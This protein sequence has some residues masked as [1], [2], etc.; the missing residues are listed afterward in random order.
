MAP[1]E[2]AYSLMQSGR[3]DPE[4]VPPAG[5]N[6]RRHFMSRRFDRLEGGEK[7]HMQSLCALRIS[8]STGGATR[9]SKRC[10]NP[11][12]NCPWKR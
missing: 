11:Q 12:L 1:I 9:T 3:R 10:Y 5:R 4:R 2:Y 7:R 6:G 8:I